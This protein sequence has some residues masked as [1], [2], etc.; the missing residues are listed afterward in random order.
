[1]VPINYWAVFSG[2]IAAMVLGYVWYGPLFGKQWVTLMGWSKADMDA[3]MKE[4]VGPKYV[5]QGVGAVLMAFVLAH[6]I[7]FAGSYLHT[8]GVSAGM[9]GAWWSW[10]GFIVP[11]SLGTIL[12]DGKP[13]KLWF[14]NIGYYLATLIVMGI[15]FGLW[16]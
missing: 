5:L 6:A 4:G 9:Q 7:V 16:V 3:K 13:W 1:M 14:I 12:W 15:I 8:S 2:A 10:I 11:V